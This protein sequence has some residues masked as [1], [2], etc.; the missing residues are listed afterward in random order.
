M[1]TTR[2]ITL[3]LL[4]SNSAVFALAFLLILVKQ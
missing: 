1:I 4:I 3:S 2:A